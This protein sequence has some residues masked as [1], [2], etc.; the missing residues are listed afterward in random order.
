MYAD[1]A[2]S[3][4]R[5]GTWYRYEAGKRKGGKTIMVYARYTNYPKK[6]SSHFLDK[7]GLIM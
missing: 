2:D 5:G 1:G 3:A 7:V 6:R 4:L